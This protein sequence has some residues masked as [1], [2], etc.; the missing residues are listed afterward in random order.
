MSDKHLKE[1][2][3]F[4]GN[5]Y[6]PGDFVVWPKAY[7]S[8]VQMAFGQVVSINRF[9][10]SKE[11]LLDRDGNPRPTIT[12][13]PLEWGRS[14]V[15]KWQQTK[16]GNIRKVTVSDHR[17]V[18][19]VDGGVYTQFEKIQEQHLGTVEEQIARLREQYA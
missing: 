16:K 12:L 6:R 7:G 15:S 3:D 9:N 1:W 8:G 5:V 18:V 14:R 10:S 19:K 4:L 17:N 11:E 2:T 13:Q